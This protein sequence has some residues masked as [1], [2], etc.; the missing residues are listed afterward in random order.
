MENTWIRY[1][2]C[3]VCENEF[4]YHKSSQ[5]CCSPECKRIRKNK[6]SCIRKKEGT[7][8]KK[9]IVCGKDF[10][11]A[12]GHYKTCSLECSAERDRQRNTTVYK[13]VHSNKASF[14]QAHEKYYQTNKEYVKQRVKNYHYNRLKTDP[15]YRLL[16]FIRKRIGVAL[17]R[18]TKTG[19]TVELLGCS[20]PLLKQYLQETAIKNGYADFDMN[21]YDRQQYHIDHIIPCNQF[22]LS[23]PEEQRKCFHYTN[24]Q[25]L[26]AKHNLEKSDKLD[27]KI[28]A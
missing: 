28:S 16:F 15:E 9:C 8:I 3:V 14:K 5:C 23:N 19:K 18:N 22:D 25:I 12:T 2:K 1:K 17:K 20:V 7:V 4:A 11:T 27:Y 24:L 26:S 21:N 13:E 6:L 10:R